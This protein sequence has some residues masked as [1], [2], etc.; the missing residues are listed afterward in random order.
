MFVVDTDWVWILLFL[1][2]GAYAV[3]WWLTK[4]D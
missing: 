2:G 1:A 3:Y 4:L